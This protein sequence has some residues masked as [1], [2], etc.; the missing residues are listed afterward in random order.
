[1]ILMMTA[2]WPSESQ[3]EVASR[4]QEIASKLPVPDFITMRGPYWYTSEGIQHA[5]IIY[6]TD[7]SKIIDAYDYLV[8][9]QRMY[10]GIPGFKRE[11]K[12]CYELA[13]AEKTNPPT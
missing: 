2:S 6:E 13:D 7:R 8:T 12:L 1:M 9:F 10:V 3:Q 4:N 11:I 5:F